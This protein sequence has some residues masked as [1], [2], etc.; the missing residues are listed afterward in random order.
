MSHENLSRCAI[1]SGVAVVPA[2][3]TLPIATSPMGGVGV[4]KYKTA[5]TMPVECEAYPTY[6]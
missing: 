1:V 3:A 5:N 2:V 6:E 4:V